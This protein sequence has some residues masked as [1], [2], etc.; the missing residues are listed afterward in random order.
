AMLLAE[1][2]REVVNF[3]QTTAEQLS[4]ETTFSIVPAY[5]LAKNSEDEKL[6]DK[7]VQS[8][9]KVGMEMDYVPGS[10]FH[11]GATKVAKIENQGQFNPVSYITFLAAKFQ[12]LGG[13]LIEG[14][15][16]TG[17]DEGDTI[18]VKTSV[19]SILCRNVVYAT[20]IPPGVNILHFRNAPYRSYVIGVKLKGGN[21]PNALAYDLE[22]PYHYYRSQKIKGEEYLIVG[23]EDHKTGHEEN[24]MKCF[25]ALEEHVRKHFDVSEISFR[26]SSQFFVPTDGLPYIGQL[27]GASNN[28]YVA[29]GFNG[30]GMMLGTASGLVISD[31]IIK[32]ES[33]YSKLFNPSRVKPVAG[34]SNFVK[35][36]ADVVGNL[37][38]GRFSA[39]QIESLTDLKNGEAKVVNLNGSVLAIY[40]DE[41]GELHSL[42]SACT[43]IK[44]TVGW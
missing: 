15:R 10:P 39:K 9:K 13:I 21:Y 8:A 28:V 14:C 37:V 35:E 30:D 27:P 4:P 40:K 41:K 3:I 1:A 26:W 5:Y 6:L 29:T 16:A 23:G 24:T 44:C 36:A 33:K 43:H 34:F 38:S 25:S 17:L 20:H 32:G 22:D 42:S 31:M 11:V 18:E 12:E 19:S 2:M 7:I